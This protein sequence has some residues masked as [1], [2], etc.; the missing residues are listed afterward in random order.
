[1]DR[2]IVEL[3]RGYAKAN[4]FTEAEWRAFLAPLT[5]QESLAMFVSLWQAGERL[6]ATGRGNFTH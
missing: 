6:A 1:M 3:L 5:P 2:R 4:E